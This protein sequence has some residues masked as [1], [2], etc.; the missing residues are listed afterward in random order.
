MLSPEEIQQVKA[1][2]EAG[3]SY[4]VNIFEGQLVYAFEQGQ[5]YDRTWQNNPYG[6]EGVERNNVISFEDLINAIGHHMF[7]E[8][9]E[10]LG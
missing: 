8:L 2:F 6:G 9:V 10:I 1:L 3:K 7:D 4:R 5:F